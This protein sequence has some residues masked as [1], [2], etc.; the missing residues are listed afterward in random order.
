[1]PIRF[2]ARFVQ[3]TALLTLT[4]A[5]A[6]CDKQE[7]A[8]P[9]QMPPVEVSV[10]AVQAERT[11]LTTELPGRVEATRVAEVRARVPGIVLKRTFEEGTDV[12]AGQVLFQ[13]D[14]APL[15]AAFNAAKANLASAE[16]ALVNAQQLERRYA[17]LVKVQAVSKQEYDQALAAYRQAQ[18]A[19]AQQ[20][21]A[22]EQARL[23]LGYATVDAPIAGRVGNALVTEGALVGQ[24]EV[25]PMAVVQQID[26]IYVNFTQSTN[27]LLRLQE[28]ALAGRLSTKGANEAPVTLVLGTGS[29]YKHQGRLL[30]SGITVDPTTGQISVRAE[31]PNPDKQLLPGMF[32]RGRVAQAVAEQAISVPPQAVQR[33]PDGSAYVL[34]VDQNNT[35]Q[36]RPVQTGAMMTDKWVI[37]SGLQ[38]GDRVVLN[39]FQQVRPGSPVKPVPVGAQAAAGTA[40]AG[41]ATAPGAAA[42]GPDAASAGG[43]SGAGAQ[44]TPDASSSQQ[45]Q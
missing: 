3:G 4:L 15:Q 19:V 30:F 31:F 1:M 41:G 14:P 16:A 7:Q 28:A 17:P 10:L 33:N 5:L 36:I 44:A 25:T 9:P 32:V 38:E 26:P 22:L 43:A 18:A 24:G 12:K 11:A 8:A 13:I 20:K 37:N 39:R 40:A 42:P 35:A 21:A 2:R 6:A 45:A 29:E 34:I 27:E 23:N